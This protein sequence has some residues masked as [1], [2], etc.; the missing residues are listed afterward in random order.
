MLI[1][2]RVCLL[3]FMLLLFSL[4]QFDEFGLMSDAVVDHSLTLPTTLSRIGQRRDQHAAG[5]RESQSDEG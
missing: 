3:S 1:T 5:E 4:L 2:L